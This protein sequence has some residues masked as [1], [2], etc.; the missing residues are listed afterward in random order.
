MEY[1]KLGKTDIDVSVMALGCWP[2]A[3]GAVWGDQDDEQSIVT[4]QAALDVGI[5]SLIR[6]KGT[7]MGIPSACWGV[8][9]RGGVRKRLLRPR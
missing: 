9:W 7:R 4:V 5:I 1:R 3:G 8:G 6:R 2:F